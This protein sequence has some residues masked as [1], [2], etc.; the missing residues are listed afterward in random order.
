MD[1]TTILV[2]NLIMFYAVIQN[3]FGIK[4][5]HAKFF[6]EKMKIKNTQQEQ[7]IEIT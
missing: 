7:L 1:M 6:E 2:N 5:I 4:E 3:F